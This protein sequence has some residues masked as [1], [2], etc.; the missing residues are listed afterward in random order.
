MHGEHVVPTDPIAALAYSYKR[1][2]TPEQSKGD[3]ARRQIKMAADWI[4]ANPGYKLDEKLTMFDRGVSGWRGKN[5]NA[6][7]CLGKF[8]EH[9]KAGDIA[10]GS[11]LLVERLDRISRDY[12]L[13]AANLVASIIKGGVDVIRLE[14]NVRYDLQAIRGDIGKLLTMVL[15]FAVASGE[16]EK[17]SQRLREVWRAKHARAALTKEVSTSLLPF[18]LTCKRDPLTGQRGKIEEHPV[19]ADIV[20]RI[21]DE[22]LAGWGK[23]AIAKRLNTDGVPTP[24]R[25]PGSK[26][27]AM[28]WRDATIGRTLASAA[29]YGAYQ[30][31]IDREHPDGTVTLHDPYGQP[32]AGYYPAVIDQATFDAVAALRELNRVKAG[33]PMNSTGVPGEVKHILAF[34]ARCPVCQSSMT[35]V[36]KTKGT[37]PRYMCSKALSGA[38][39]ACVRTYVP[40]ADVERALCAAA[41]QLAAAA[42]GIDA[43]VGESLVLIEARHTAAQTKLSAATDSIIEAFE[44]GVKVS[45]TVYAEQARLEAERDALAVEL[46]DLR[47]KATNTQPNMV[48]Q[49]IGRMLS[50]LH[51]YGEG[52]TGPLG[53]TLPQVNAVLRSCF[54][55]VVIDYPNNA[56][57]CSWTH[58]PPPTSIPFKVTP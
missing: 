2:S 57:V 39:G 14:G 37:A 11:V 8:L 49:R 12:P 4:A 34:L 31:H 24:P 52:D 20:R 35:R 5:L 29:T 28:R 44:A 16:S 41:D 10:P 53:A 54:E 50:A 58:G 38:A 42:P 21:F 18:W 26:K 7:T 43:T 47:L 46:K 6:E 30:P 15:E 36:S 27:H 55:R 25:N 33:V 1:F 45:P 23:A 40:V 17:K 22:Y 32:V 3:S 48:K 56:L 9:I 13:D 19:Y 51:A